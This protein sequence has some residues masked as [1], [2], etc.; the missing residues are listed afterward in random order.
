M[1]ESEDKTPNTTRHIQQISNDGLGERQDEQDERVS[2]SLELYSLNSYET[3][4]SRMI[5]LLLD[6]MWVNTYNY[7]NNHRLV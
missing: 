3:C 2:Y 1:R 6:C 4:T 5:E 7:G